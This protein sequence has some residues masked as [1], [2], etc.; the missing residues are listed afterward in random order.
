ME[1]CSAQNRASPPAV[2]ALLGK[3][4]NREADPCVTLPGIKVLKIER[5]KSY[6]KCQGQGSR[7]WRAPGATNSW[8]EDREAKRREEARAGSQPSRQVGS[9]GRVLSR[10]KA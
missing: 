8:H 5:G 1:D 6:H 4:V 2:Y 10:G 3:T 9:P 7:V